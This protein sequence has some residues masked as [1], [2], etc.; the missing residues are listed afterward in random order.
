VRTAAP[1]P[2][3]KRPTTFNGV[4]TAPHRL[5]LSAGHGARVADEN[6]SAFGVS[7]KHEGGQ[8]QAVR[9][10]TRP[11]P[12]SPRPL[13]P[14]PSLRRL[15]PRTPQTSTP[16]PPR[17]PLH[18]FRGRQPRRD[19]GRRRR[20]RRW[21][22]GGRHRSTRRMRGRPTRL[23]LNV[24]GD[25]SVIWYCACRVTGKRK[26]RKGQGEGE[27]HT[28]SCGATTGDVTR[29]QQATWSA[30]SRS[31]Y[32]DGDVLLRKMLHY[33]YSPYSSIP[34]WLSPSPWPIPRRRAAGLG[35]TARGDSRQMAFALRA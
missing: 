24:V 35:H 27:S 33:V 1:W 5:R 10:G 34:T 20:V 28:E 3:R 30:V 6:A 26:G 18:G 2:P 25:L 16:P 11:T 22:Y 32:R 12:P 4:R 21:I 29:G 8:S 14:L 7:E 17:P 19:R 15:L 9:R 23:K 13:P 31:L